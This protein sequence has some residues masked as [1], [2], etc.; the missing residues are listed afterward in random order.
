MSVEAVDNYARI[1]FHF[2]LLHGMVLAQFF[3]F[4]S[5]CNIS[6]NGKNVIGKL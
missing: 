1:T 6:S 4:F 3:F 2:S 5:D